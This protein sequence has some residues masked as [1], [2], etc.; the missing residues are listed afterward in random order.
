VSEG[1]IRDR[2]EG[3]FVTLIFIAAL[4]AEDDGN[5]IKITGVPNL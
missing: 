5:M 3:E 4:D 1:W 2:Q